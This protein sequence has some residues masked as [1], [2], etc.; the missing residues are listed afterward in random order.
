MGD[1]VCSVLVAYEKGE[2]PNMGQM[3]D[4]L[5]NGTEEVKIAT[6]KKV[7]LLALNGEPLPQLLMSVIRFLM[8]M[9]SHALKK[10]LLL[11]LEV[12][13]KTSADGKLLPEMILVCNALRN[14]LNH[15]N[16]YIRGATLRLLCRLREAEII[17][18]LIPSVRACLQHRHAYVLRAAVLA[19]HALFQNHEHL[20]PDA[21]ELIEKFLAAEG[22]AACRR[23]A[24]AMLCAVAGERAEAYLTS[25]L[26]S[27]A[28]MPDVLQFVA[29]ELL[30]HL[31]RT[32]VQQRPRYIKSVYPLL[33][34]ANP[35]LAFE[36]AVCLLSLTSLPAAVR[37][38][39]QTF[40]NLVCSHSDNNVKLIVLERLALVKEA[41]PRVLAELV[42]DLMRAL[43]SPSMAVRR[44]VLGMAMQLVGP[45]NIDEVIA[46]LRKEIGKTQSKEFEHGAEYRQLLIETVHSCAVRFPTTAAA[47]SVLLI[48]FLGDA[49]IAT[50][51][52]VVSFL[53]QVMH[54]HPAQRPE[55]LGKLASA[56]PTV[57]HSDVYRAALWLLAQYAASPAEVDQAM[58]AV[59]EQLGSPPF[60]LPA[61]AEA[62][63]NAA[64]E[65]DA[66]DGKAAPLGDKSKDPVRTNSRLVL[67]DGSY[68]TQSAF[69]EN[70]ALTAAAATN[71]GAVTMQRHLRALV[72]QGDFFLAAV[73]ASA[74]TKLVLKLRA[75]PAAAVSQ[76]AKNALTADVLLTLVGLLRLGR[77]P[78]AVVID[79]DNEDRIALCV[80]LLAAPPAA[81]I[82]ARLAASLLTDSAAAFA[83]LLKEPKST[84]P[85]AAAPVAKT[86]QA[87]ALLR[88]RQLRARNAVLDDTEDVTDAPDVDARKL[89]LARAVGSAETAS[90]AGK[91]AAAAA[92][93]VYQLTGFSDALYAEAHV[94]AHQFDIMIEMHVT[95][96][97]AD[98]L[99]NVALELATLGDLRLLERPQTYTFG[100]YDKKVIR[101]AI[102][103]SS[104]ETG[105]I[106]GNLVYDLAGGAGAGSD[107]NCVILSDLHVDVMDYL[108]P[109]RCP[110]AD[111]RRMWSEFEWENKVSVSTPISEPAAFLNHLVRATNMACLTPGALDA[112]ADCAFLSAN[113]YARSTFGED[114]LANVSLERL[115]DGKLSGYIRIRSKTQG[116][117]LSLGDKIATKQKA[118]A[119]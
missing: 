69:T 31:A 70:A 96:Q 72:V 107:K 18:P 109:A 41:H 77:A 27:L 8:P 30:R 10:H 62:A 84:V 115:A 74:L 103:V 56:L 97:T 22:D 86:V 90:V 15:P 52:N 4:A 28:T 5:E 66:K 6:I 118:A 104:T 75:F 119:A 93:R 32:N 25:V 83:E 91:A 13:D 65:A 36:A 73:L 112:D 51:A 116:I 67:P 7:L 63:A 40:I 53:R 17:E 108:A 110:E 100:P 68:A 82:V 57:R 38:A 43:G 47:V 58:T 37:L 106:F 61:A 71:V 60:L 34:S 105:I 20:V 49:N 50:G 45:R 1:K 76:Q 88:W 114:A 35:A 16:E 46:F 99:Q 2:P 39:A 85:D 55:L 95:N 59:K 24:F 89:E 44:T 54:E 102:K 94:A 80:R 81:P 19:L 23:N 48:D 101:A 79:G 87:D 78:G 64:A 21:P 3:R 29:I 111:F 98:T 42:M 26:E 92:A 113:L 117:A 11:Y 12:I 9:K 14:D 33:S